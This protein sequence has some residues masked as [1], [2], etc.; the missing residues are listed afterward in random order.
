MSSSQSTKPIL[1]TLGF[2]GVFKIQERFAGPFLA[3]FQKELEFKPRHYQKFAGFQQAEPV[4]CYSVIQKPGFV[5]IQTPYA[6]AVQVGSSPQFRPYIQFADASW[7]QPHD[8]WDQ[9]VK[10]Q[11]DLHHPRA[12]PEQRVICPR[13]LD[14]LQKFRTAFVKAGTGTGKCLGVDTGVLMADGTHK[15]VQDIVVGDYV[16]SPSG[17]GA[18][19]ESL[20]R[21]RDLMYKI[22]TVK[23][24]S[25]VVNQHHVLSLVVT[26]NRPTYDS[27]GRKY[28]PGDF[29]EIEVKDYLT[30]T[31]KFKH[32]TKLW[33]PN[34]P[35]TF[36]QETSPEF[37]AYMLGVWLGDGTSRVT[38]I[39]NGDPEVIQ[40]LQE[41]GQ[42]AGMKVWNSTDI[43]WHLVTDRGQPN[44]F[45]QFLQSRNL[46]LNKHIPQ[47]YLMA[48]VNTRYQ[49]L[50]GL[51]DTD[52]YLDRNGCTFSYVC[53]QESLAKN[54]QQL[55]LSLGYQVK[56][57]PVYKSC[58]SMTEPGCYYLLSITGNTDLIPTK[59]SRKQA[60]P[61]QQVKTVNRFGFTVEPLGE[62][63][64]YGFNLATEDKLFL[65]SDF[66]VSHNS[67]MALW[68]ACQFK[69]RTLIVV[70]RDKLL[71]H[72]EEECQTIL[73]MDK[74]HLGY[75]Q[76][77]VRNID[78]PIVIAT[79][80]SL[81]SV[82]KKDPSFLKDRFGYVVYDEADVLGA[83]EFSKIFKYVNARFSCAFSAT[84]KRGDGLDDVFWSHFGKEHKIEAKGD[85][86]PM[87]L[88]VKEMTTEL[89]PRYIKARNYTLGLAK[90]LNFNNQAAQ[91]VSGFYRSDRSA[92]LVM[93]ENI[94]HLALF[95]KCLINLGVNPA[96]IGEFFGSAESGSREMTK[97]L[98]Q[99]I[100]PAKDKDDKYFEWVKAEARIILA[101]YGMMDRGISIARLDTAVSLVDRSDME[102]AL[103]RI[104]RPS[105]IGMTKGYPT[106]VCFDHILVDGLHSKTR[107][108]L[109]GV[110]KDANVE[111]VRM[112][113]ARYEPRV[114]RDSEV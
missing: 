49:L 24:E 1:L 90:N 64:Y 86:L 94:Y 4:K 72:F 44:P 107:R 87:K 27:L 81:L 96:H 111:I 63:D 51:L 103:G 93:A 3:K 57:T 43:T 59:V 105:E 35:I 84:T 14:E 48:D 8:K 80:Q 40:A 75:I 55:A 19:V 53:K 37:D 88:L 30:S 7:F 66:I 62:D 108:M 104:R 29:V 109:S 11:P 15:K 67:V 56:L 60:N 73:G 26:G 18:R 31:K 68:L 50:A 34:R 78:A 13:T 6:Y 16:M 91:I 71:K 112:P 22:T 5:Y 100:T 92:I 99:V 76:Q 41:F 12:N 21:G 65:L 2:G 47:E 69:T 77:G 98:R 85:A 42:R 9:I 101:T 54:V 70:H 82:L 25:H 20:A 52:G 17:C 110:R 38:T 114:S 33:K 95:K 113:V 23:G 58:Q 106:W 83:K 97:D 74:R 32:V 89:E 10:R 102:Q 46:I 28:L 45:L 36:E 39:T 79:V 61:R